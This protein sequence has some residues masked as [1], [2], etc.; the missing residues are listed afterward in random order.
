MEKLAGVYRVL[1]PH[2][3]AVYTFHRHV[4]SDIVDAPTV[5]LLK[6]MLDDDH[7]Q[8]V[9]GEMLLEDLARTPELRERAGKWE[10]HLDVL[11]A[12]SGGVAGEHTLGGRAKIVMP[13]KAV[14]GQALR[15][16]RERE[17]AGT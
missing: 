11:L 9:E 13:P 3:L 7:Q 17:S 5:R 1:V 2:L 12:K 8:F 4:T 16:L 10:S 15:E 14:L 6:F